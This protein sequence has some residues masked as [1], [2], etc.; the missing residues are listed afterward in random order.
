MKFTKRQ[1]ANAFKILLNGRFL[2]NFIIPNSKI[3]TPIVVEGNSI[4][5][6]NLKKNKKERK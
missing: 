6:M 4:T 1:N 5:P 3:I 2:L